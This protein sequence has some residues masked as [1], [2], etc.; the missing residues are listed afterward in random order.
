M[1]ERKKRFP[2]TQERALF[3]DRQGTRLTPRSIDLL[4]RKIGDDAGLAISAHVLRHTCL[5]NLVRNGHD[6]LTN[7]ASC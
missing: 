6:L 1:E 7:G 2:D 3:L 4:L 5:T